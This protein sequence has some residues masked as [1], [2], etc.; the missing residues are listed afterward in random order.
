MS[1]GGVTQARLIRPGATYAICRRTEGRRFLLRPDAKLN[2]LFTYILAVACGVFGIELHAVTCMSTHYHLVVTVPHG[3]IS[4]A[5][6]LMN[7]YLAKSIQ[8][9]RRFVHGVVWAPG[10][11]GIVELKTPEAVVEAIVYAMVNPVV[12]ALVYRPEEWPGVT[13]TIDDI[14]GGAVLTAKRP[15]FYFGTLWV[16]SASI[17]ITIP[18]CLRDL[19]A[20]ELRAKLQEELDVQLAAARKHVKEQGWRVAGRIASMNTSPYRYAKSWETFG[21]LTPRFA[22]GRGQKEARIAAIRELRQFRADHREAKQRWIAGDRDIVFP[23]GTYWMVF[24]HRARAYSFD[25]PPW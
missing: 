8:V 19:S 5:M 3:N 24:H 20:E 10:K 4:E 7:L 2:A 25:E 22:A 21:A 11:L 18:P 13:V 15:D 17:R 12:A 16:E 9:L 1:T 14:V 23:A 6:W